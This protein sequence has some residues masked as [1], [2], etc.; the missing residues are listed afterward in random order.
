MDVG[1]RHS[2]SRASVS[3]AATSSSGVATEDDGWLSVHVLVSVTATGT[4]DGWDVEGLLFR[5]LL[6]FPGRQF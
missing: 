1:F 5:H 4:G 3:A 2:V 6:F